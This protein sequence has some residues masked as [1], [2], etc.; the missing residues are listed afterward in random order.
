MKALFQKSH[1]KK[2]F[3]FL[4]FFILCICD[5]RVGSASG[6]IQLVCPNIVLMVLSCIALSHYPLSRFRRRSFRIPA[7]VFAAGSFLALFLIWPNNYYH[8]QLISGV[9]AAILYGCVFS[10]LPVGSPALS[11]GFY[12]TGMRMDAQ[13]AGRRCLNG[14]F[15]VSGTGVCLSPIRF[16]AL[17]RTVCQYQYERAVISDG[18]LRVPVR[19]LY[20]GGKEGAGH[21]K[22][23]KLLLCLCHVALCAADH[24]PERCSGHGGCHLSGPGDHAV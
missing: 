22:M 1:F 20:P 6:E 23:G 15:C 11:D 21:C 13:I 3:Y 12:G 2:Y 10:A 16:S 7:I 18:L 5:Q 24:V 19:F 14:F 4:C 9:L 17:S 8:Y